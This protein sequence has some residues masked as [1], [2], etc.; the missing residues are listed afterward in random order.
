MAAYREIQAW[1]RQNFRFLPQSCWIADVMN[2][3]GL[4]K[5]IAANRLSSAVRTNPC[6]L[7][8]RRDA[9]VSA[10]RHFEMLPN[11]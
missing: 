7:G 3:F 2:D 6:P 10:L 11:R 8:G 5:R 4:T 9:I 1:V